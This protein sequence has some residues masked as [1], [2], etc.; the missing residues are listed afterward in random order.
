MWQGIINKVWLEYRSY[1]I[2]SVL[3][4]MMGIGLAY[5]TIKTLR[6]V[7]FAPENQGVFVEPMQPL[8]SKIAVPA[9]EI[10]YVMIWVHDEFNQQKLQKED[11]RTLQLE[12]V[13]VADET[14]RTA[15]KPRLI[16]RGDQP[17]LLFKLSKIKNEEKQNYSFVIYQRGE[18]VVGVQDPL[19]LQLKTD[20]TAEMAL[21]VGEKK[22][23]LTLLIDKV[24]TEDLVGHDISFYLRRGNQIVQGENPYACVQENSCI[25]YPA[26]LPGM[27]W[28][29]AGWAA[30]GFDD[31]SEWA[32]IW[33]PMMLAAWL[34]VGVVLLGYSLRRGQP[35]L[36]VAA[37][38]LWLFNRWSL[39]VLRVA[40]TDFVGVLFLILAIICAEQW[41]IW[42]AVLLALSLSVKQLAVLIVPIFLI[43]MWRHYGLSWKKLALVIT[44]IIVIPGAITLP[45]LIDNPTA[46]I[47][48]LMNVVERPAQSVR[49][50]APSFDEW[51]D[52]TDWGKLLPMLGLTGMV[53]VAVWR[54][55]V[56]LIQ[57]TVMVM[58]IMM[59]FTSVLYNQYFVWFI[60]FI[61]LALAR[62]RE[63]R[64][65]T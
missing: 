10:D 43:A 64:Q 56:D 17:A 13:N 40:H 1:V 5:P 65:K 63:Q 57:G 24:Y 55:E 49:G 32:M 7:E 59:A 25:G 48:G 30:L 6:T 26:H 50:F 54:K 15:V 37:M 3:L 8:T 23:W 33:R 45:F 38:G 12:V 62:Y 39:D 18:G 60:P 35:G 16:K 52:V 19:G 36:G 61:P 51:L 58:A 22:N 31:L 42:A 11:Y 28:F 2:A 21:E 27:Y 44:M 46:T 47:Q 41:P 53:Y 29:A 9:G 34:G 4:I 14:I 20:E